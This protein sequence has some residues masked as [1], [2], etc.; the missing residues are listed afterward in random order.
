M[1]F[2]LSCLASYSRMQICEYLFHH[3]LHFY[4]SQFSKTDLSFL[5][6]L[7]SEPGHK[8]STCPS[9][10]GLDFNTQ[11]LRKRAKKHPPAC[12]QEND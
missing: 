11:K 2:F 10:G 8:S 3:A 6:Y 7:S 12:T 4:Y 9:R 5:Q 1:D